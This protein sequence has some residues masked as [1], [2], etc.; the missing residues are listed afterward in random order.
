MSLRGLWRRMWAVLGPKPVLPPEGD[1]ER[2]AA[3]QYVLDNLR[4]AFRADA[5]D[6][7]L[8]RV[9]EDGWVILRALGNCSGC[10]AKVLTVQGAL[11][12]KLREHCGPW[13]QGVR[14]DDD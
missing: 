8:V 13:F 12:P 14:A 9:Q 5:G 6:M 3:V 4:P 2:S 10:S 11:A 1:P 7:R